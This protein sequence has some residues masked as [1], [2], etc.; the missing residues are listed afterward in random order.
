MHPVSGTTKTLA[1]I[2]SPVGHSGS[3]AMHNYAAQLLGLDYVYVAFDVK[4]EGV[5]AALQAM[6]ALGIRGYNVTMPCKTAAAQ[7]ADTLSPGAALVGACNTIINDGGILTGYSTDGEGFTRS[8]REHG[9]DV[10]GKRLVLVGA[11]GAGMSILAQ[12][13]LEGAR[14]VTV[15]QRRNA[16]WDRVTEKAW[17]I[18]RA[19]PT[20]AIKVCDLYDEALAAEE[21][22]ACDVLANATSV[23][24]KP[25]EDRSILSSPVLLG[26]LR[27]G[28]V[29]FDAV[30]NPVETLLLRQARAAGC[31]TVDGRQM[32]FWQGASAFRLF[33]GHEMPVEAVREKFFS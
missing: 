20:C 11:G 14:S 30:Y 7:W 2:G 3:P 23:G 15:L 17:Q 6:R 16:S 22:A 31:T 4:E 28:L 8:L 5:P 9:A 1:L 26:A 29:V 12:S 33:T 27:P 25:H 21:I 13:A 18:Q 32:L 10:S 19:C 24:M